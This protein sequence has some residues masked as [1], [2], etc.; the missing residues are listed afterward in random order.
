MD[1]PMVLETAFTAI[2]MDKTN[3]WV[4][5]QNLEI[6]SLLSTATL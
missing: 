4:L 6:Y 1:F 2:K 5:G 3:K